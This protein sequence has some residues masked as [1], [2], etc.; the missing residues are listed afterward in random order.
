MISREKDRAG[1]DHNARAA[2]AA[3]Q[4]VLVAV[5]IGNI[6]DI[7]PRALKTLAGAD[8]I[9]AE[10]TRTTM[11]LFSS[12]EAAGMT[13]ICPDEDEDFLKEARHKLISY[14][15]HNEAQRRD[16]LLRYLSEGKTVA[17]VT[18]AGTPG[19]SDP[20]EDIVREAVS[21]GYQV[22]AVPG[23]VAFVNGLIM[24]GL[25]TRRFV[26]E[27]FLHNDNKERRTVLESLRY[28]S[29]TIVLY[30]APHRL[31]KT[32]GE[33]SEIM[34]SDRKLVLARELTKKYEEVVMRSIGEWLAYFEDNEPRGEYVMIIE[35][36]QNGERIKARETAFWSDMTVQEHFEYYVEK[37]MKR[38]DAVKAVAADRSL[39]KR[40]IYDQVMR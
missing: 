13:A 27:G 7:T 22:T 17:V 33:L 8:V 35:G 19:I 1:N 38:N 32:I 21:Q 5:P 18:D 34:G 24:S 15:D 37:G 10:D 29:R 25:S 40:E 3:G 9:A 6:N 26:F 20:G 2:G 4:L 12:L 31:V 14:H 36:L 39:P 28:E 23:A 30:E 11:N 16:T